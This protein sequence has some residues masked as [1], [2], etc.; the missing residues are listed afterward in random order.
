MLKFTKY[1]STINLKGKNY[2]NFIH[3]NKLIKKEDFDELNYF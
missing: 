3:N 2:T 1:F